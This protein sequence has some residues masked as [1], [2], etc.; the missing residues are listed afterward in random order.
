[1]LIDD[2]TLRSTCV[3][4][5]GHAVVGWHY[6][7]RIRKMR[8]DNFV[9]NEG[10]SKISCARHRD[11]EDQVAI[12]LAGYEAVELWGCGHVPKGDSADQKQVR[13]LLQSRGIDEHSRNGM[14]VRDDARR[15]SREVLKQHQAKIGQLA[16]AL[17]E[18]TE[19]ETPGGC[20]WRMLTGS[21]ITKVLSS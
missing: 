4:E 6:G 18:A 21:E 12:W 3:H 9:G 19:H 7:L 2:A 14:A 1:M 20:R 16:S 17:M 5:A 8:V 11:L 10:H 15:R 13:E